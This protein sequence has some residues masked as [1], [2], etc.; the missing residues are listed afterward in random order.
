MGSFD[1]RWDLSTPF[2][3]VCGKILYGI[4]AALA[5]THLG[6]NVNPY[7]VEIESTLNIHLHDFAPWLTATCRHQI[8]QKIANIIDTVERYAY[9]HFLMV[10]H[11]LPKRKVRN[12]HMDI[13]CKFS[14]YAGNVKTMLSKLPPIPEG[15]EHDEIMVSVFAFSTLHVQQCDDLGLVSATTRV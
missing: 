5:Q 8:P 10:S 6:K 15:V 3:P 1:L 13:M 2:A 11:L 4:R 14:P 7:W 12:V 9:A